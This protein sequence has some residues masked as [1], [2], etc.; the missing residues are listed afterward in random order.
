MSNGIVAVPNSLLVAPDRRN[1]G[2]YQVLPPT[3]C[4]ALCSTA[5]GARLGQTV[6]SPTRIIEHYSS[7]VCIETIKSTVQAYCRSIGRIPRRSAISS[8]RQHSTST[9]KGWWNGWTLVACCCTCNL[10]D[11]PGGIVHIGWIRLRVSRSKKVLFKMRSFFAFLDWWGISNSFN[12]LHVQHQR[13]REGL[14]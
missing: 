10:C 6:C 11:I 3:L 9:D 2:F 7:N 5:S 12:T 4:D 8:H 13:R 1:T 14:K